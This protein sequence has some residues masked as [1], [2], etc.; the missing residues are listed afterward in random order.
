MHK[1]IDHTNI[2]VVLDSE[3]VY[4]IFHHNLEI[5]KLT[6]TNINRII[7]QTISSL[8]AS[9]RFDSGLNSDLNE[10]QI[11]LVPYSRAHFM[12]SFYALISVEKTHY[13]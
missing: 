2:S 10:L 7:A 6:Y 12:L 5:E 3:A 9:I 11:N 4:D 1:L 8:A 13:Q